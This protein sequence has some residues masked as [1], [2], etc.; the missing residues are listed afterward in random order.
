MVDEKRCDQVSQRN[1]RTCFFSYQADGT[2][3]DT[4]VYQTVKAVSGSTTTSGNATSEFYVERA[5]VSAIIDRKFEERV[6]FRDCRHLEH[7]STWFTYGAAHEFFPPIAVYHSGFNLSHYAFDRGGGDALGRRLEQRHGALHESWPQT[8][9]N[10][11]RAAMDLVVHTGCCLHDASNGCHWGIMP[12]L[13]ADKK[14]LLKT[15]HVVVAYLRNS[16]DLFILNTSWL[17]Q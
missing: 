12:Y 1:S 9:H 4:K 16:Y 2:R 15:V 5:T 7:K 17:L 6:L 3:S 13:T 10:V 11:I 14:K 8:P